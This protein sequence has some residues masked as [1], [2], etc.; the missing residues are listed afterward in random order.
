VS[1]KNAL[2]CDSGRLETCRLPDSY[3][4]GWTDFVRALRLFAIF[5]R[6]KSTGVRLG[7][8]RDEATRRKHQVSNVSG[9]EPALVKRRIFYDGI[10]TSVFP[11]SP[12]L[13][14]AQPACSLALSVGHSLLRGHRPFSPVPGWR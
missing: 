8:L 6:S 4:S 7:L 14:R 12:F 9:P 11:G 5:D 3:L 1:S 10:R 2:G 13:I